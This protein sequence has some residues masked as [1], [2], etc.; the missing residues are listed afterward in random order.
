MKNAPNNK[1]SV[2]EQDFPSFVKFTVTL[3]MTKR[4]KKPSY[5]WEWA[6]CMALSMSEIACGQRLSQ[7]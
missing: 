3:H 1:C 5:F 2:P 6:E 4:Y 7:T